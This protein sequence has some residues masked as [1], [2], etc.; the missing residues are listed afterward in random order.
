MT[1]TPTRII[2]ICRE[3][4]GGVAPTRAQVV[5]AMLDEGYSLKRARR[6]LRDLEDNGLIYLDGEVVVPRF[7][8]VRNTAY[9]VPS[10]TEN[11]QK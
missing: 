9:V 1:H 6:W 7:T 8:L 4:N 2:E 5:A 10:L 3:R 11:F